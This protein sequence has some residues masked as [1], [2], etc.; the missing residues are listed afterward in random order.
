MLRNIKS[1]HG[2]VV[3]ASDGYIGHVNDFYFDDVTWAIRYLFIDGGEW[4]AKRQVLLSPHAFDQFSTRGEVL[5]VNLTRKQV[6]ECPQSSAHLPI[7]RQIEEDY[8]HHYG[9]PAYW[10]GEGMWGVGDLPVVRQLP[11]PESTHRHGHERP[12]DSHLRSTNAILGYHIQATDGALGTV[13]DFVMDDESW[14]IREVLVETGHWY[15]G[16]AIM[17]N[18]SV[19]SQISYD[20]SKLFVNLTK[21]DIR[22]TEANHVAIH[23]AANH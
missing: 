8:Y 6:E 1:I 14:S 10:I 4:M 21:A 23:C 11:V 20:E 19:I 7:S 22:D 12:E 16:K 9:W 15:A 17:I 13:C 3:A 5:Q 2:K 18:P